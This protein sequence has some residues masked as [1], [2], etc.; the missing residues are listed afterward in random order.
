MRNRRLVISMESEPQLVCL[1]DTFFETCHVSRK[2]V[3]YG[4]QTYANL[5]LWVFN[6]VALILFN[7][8]IL[9]D[10]GFPFPCTLTLFHMLFCSVCAFFLVVTRRVD[11]CDIP[12]DVFVRGILPVAALFAV[13]LYSNNLAYHFLSVPMLQ[14]IK[15]MT[16]AAVYVTGVLLQVRG[17]P[18]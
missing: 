2:Q 12:R 9:V 5:A 3:G 18:P 15:A 16:P 14:M 1:P 13:S 17:C 10:W 8:Y 7:K 11:V 6:S 4:V